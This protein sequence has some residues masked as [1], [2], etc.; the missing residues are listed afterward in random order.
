IYP[1]HCSSRSTV[2]H[3]VSVPPQ[4]KITASMLMTASCQRPPTAAQG[5][6]RAV[7]A[8]RHEELLGSAPTALEHAAGPGDPPRPACAWD[9]PPARVRSRPPIGSEAGFRELPVG[10]SVG[11]AL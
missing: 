7:R 11:M 2:C 10:G 1:L 3:G 5:F 9:E 6:C 8:L 4:S